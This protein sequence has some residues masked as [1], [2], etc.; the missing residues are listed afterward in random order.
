[1]GDTSGQHSLP[2]SLNPSTRTDVDPDYSPDGRRIAFTSNRSG[3]GAIWVSGEDGSNL[4]R[5][6]PADGPSA[7]FPRWSPDGQRIV[8][9][10]KP[11]G[12]RDICVIHVE[13]K[14]IQCLTNDSAE[15]GNPAWSRNGQWV[16]FDSRRGGQRQVWKIPTTGRGVAVQVTRDGGRVPRESLDGKHVYYV[17][18][19][20]DPSGLWRVPVDGG[21][22][23]QILDSVSRN[24]ALTPDGIYYLRGPDR[25]GIHF[26]EHHE[27]ASGASKRI[28]SLAGPPDVG[29]TVSPDGQSIVY[30]QY[31]HFDA[32]LMLVEN[33]R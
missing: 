21:R 10:S 18:P 30:A 32:D 15:E 14:S 24:F 22:E 26:I 12:L 17:K 29:F 3:N 25:D 9:V 6:T 19:Q 27:F 20:P 5:L 33:F 31:D 1:M 4:T 7:R 23:A 16:Y 11:G 28:A 8:F 13:T 2:Q